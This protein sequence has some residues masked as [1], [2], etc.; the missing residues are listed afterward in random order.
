M[1]TSAHWSVHDF[2]VYNKKISLQIKKS[3]TAAGRKKKSSFSVQSFSPA[4]FRDQ[5]ATRG[6]LSKKSQG[7]E[8][9]GNDY[10]LQTPAFITLLSHLLSCFLF[11][12]TEGAHIFDQVLFFS[13]SVV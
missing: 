3:L 5:P 8:V 7:R 11:Q 4:F 9:D 10:L 12:P 2:P 13:L 6:N 1:C